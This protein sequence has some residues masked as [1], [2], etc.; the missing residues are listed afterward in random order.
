M[1][2]IIRI[3]EVKQES[4]ASRFHAGNPP[5]SRKQDIVDTGHS[6]YPLVIG[7]F[8]IIMFFMQR[9]ALPAF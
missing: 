7:A 2:R 9:Y 5:S 6:L 4:P 1:P 8:L 3:L